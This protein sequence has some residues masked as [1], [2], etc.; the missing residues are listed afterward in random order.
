MESSY[1]KFSENYQGKMEQHRNYGSFDENQVDQKKL[2][3]DKIVN[4]VRMGVFAVVLIGLVV[5]VAVENKKVGRWVADFLEWVEN[6]TVLGMVVFVLVYIVAT[7]LF[8][9]GLILTLGAGFVYN[10]VYGLSLGLVIAT[11]VVFVGASIGSILAML[12]G[13]YVF[14]ES[15]RARIQKYPK[16]MAIEDAVQEEGLKLV[17]LLRLSPIIPFNAFN[18]FMGITSVRFKDYSLGSFGLLPGT[19]AY[20]YFGTALGS[21]SE[22]A[23][24]KTQGGA[25]ELGFIIGGSVLA[26]G[27]VIY[28]SYVAK[29]KI[30]TIIEQRENQNYQSPDYNN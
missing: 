24:G 19:L 3:K 16:L 22:A 12:M 9:P 20:A 23:E 30:N 25:L 13:R 1:S 17:T 18:Y 21:I 7:V 2:R 6:N 5:F 15:L 4:R 29:K 27:A 11:S 10:M 28:V 14:R 8:V 26:L